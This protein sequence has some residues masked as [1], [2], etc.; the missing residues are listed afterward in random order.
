MMTALIPVDGS[1]TALRAVRRFAALARGT[2]DAFAILMTVEPEL[3][4]VDRM[5]GGSPDAARRFGQPL[6]DKAEKLLAQARS[7]LDRVGVPSSSSVEFGDPAE[8]IVARAKDWS[9]DLIVIGS[10][11]RGTIGSLLQGSVA[12]KVLHHSDL[13]VLLVR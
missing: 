11:R 9:V 13:P 8:T 4:L 10:E 12:Q 1:E 3:P 7:E 6:R 5:A 2:P